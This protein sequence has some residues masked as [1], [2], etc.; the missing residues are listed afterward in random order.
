[1]QISK[2][3]KYGLI[4]ALVS[5]MFISTYS[6][7]SKI[8]LE[9][10]S[11]YSLAA[12][13]QLFSVITLLIFFGALSEFKNLQK[14]SYKELW[15]LI[16]VGLLSAV[17]QP[18]FLF[19]GLLQSPAINSVLIS[20]TQM[21]FVGIFSAIWLRERVT[22]HQI[23]GT[24]VMLS[25]AYFIATKGLTEH[26]MLSGGD[27]LLLG[28]AFFGALST[29][30]FKMYLSEVSP[31]LVV[32][33]RN[34]FGVILNLTLVPVIFGF[35][36]SF[37]EL[38]QTDVMITAILFALVAIVGAQYLWYKAVELIPAS[39]ASTI[40]MTS[41]FFG[42]LVAMVVLGE[43]LS[44]FHMIGGLLI[45]IGLIYSTLHRQTHTHHRRALRAKQWMH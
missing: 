25:G 6:T 40:G 33:M 2:E 31:H 4:A 18:L 16:I 5:T 27:S 10:F 8:L 45:V 23:T 22:G 24:I 34:L 41:P 42:V 11:T 12:L 43:K 38:A 26:M 3:Q 37:K 7:F 21:V 17:I 9:H 39:G 30:V 28:A 19:Q 44:F 29:N 32:L 1:M 35:Q 20:R 14:L 13:A 36:H 15:A